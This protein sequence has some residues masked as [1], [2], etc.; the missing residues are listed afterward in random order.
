MRLKRTDRKPESD[1]RPR[2]SGC[3]EDGQRSQCRRPSREQPASASQRAKPSTF[4]WFRTKGENKGGM[5]R[6]KVG[7]E[8]VK[9]NDLRGIDQAP[10]VTEVVN[11][12]AALSQ[13]CRDLTDRRDSARRPRRPAP[14]HHSSLPR[15]IHRRV[16]MSSGGPSVRPAGLATWEPAAAAVLFLEEKSPFMGSSHSRLPGPWPHLYVYIPSSP[17]VEQ[18]R[19]T[20]VYGLRVSRGWGLPA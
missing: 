14:G 8:S 1:G 5:F 3:R 12:Q 2:G 7:Q 16:L 9:A 17:S 15:A 11:A 19:W 20:C 13:A 10:A 6:T 18:K 4:L